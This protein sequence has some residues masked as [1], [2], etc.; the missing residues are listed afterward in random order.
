MRKKPAY[1]PEKVISLYQKGFT[2]TSIQN[3]TGCPSEVA[4]RILKEAGI[5]NAKRHYDYF[6]KQRTN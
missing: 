4:S 6:S 1:T 5:F 3:L 2:L